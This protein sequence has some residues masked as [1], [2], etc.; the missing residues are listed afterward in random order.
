MRVSVAVRMRVCVIVGMRVRARRRRA[1]VPLAGFV[2]DGNVPAQDVVRAA[3]AADKQ[4]ISDVRVFDV[5]DGEALGAGKKSVGITAVLQPTERTLTE[6][7]LDR[8][9]GNIKTRV[10]KATGGTL[11]T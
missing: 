7:D 6:A 9:A 2:V 10:E 5:F 11:R 8:I 3:R 1:R 4:L